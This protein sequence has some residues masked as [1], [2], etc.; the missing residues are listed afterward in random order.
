MRRLLHKHLVRHLSARK[1]VFVDSI[2][3]PGSL[4][5]QR[6]SPSTANGSVAAMMSATEIVKMMHADETRG[7]ES[8]RNDNARATI[9]Q[10]LHQRD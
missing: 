10:D 4:Y 7:H 3:L 6:V 1:P 5:Q 2:D 9:L 8:R